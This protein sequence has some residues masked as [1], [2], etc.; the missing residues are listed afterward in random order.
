[1]ETFQSEDA[2]DGLVSRVPLKHAQKT[3]KRSKKPGNPTAPF[4]SL[5]NPD[6]RTFSKFQFELDV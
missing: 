5:P 1:M 4:D 6:G 2:V 3:T